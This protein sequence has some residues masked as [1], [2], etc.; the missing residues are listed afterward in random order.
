MAVKKKITGFDTETTGMNF[1]AGGIND[2]DRVCEIG[3]LVHQDGQEIDRYHTYVNPER[4]MPQDAYQIH[5]LSDSFLAD[6]PKFAEIYTDLLDFLI[7]H[8]AWENCAYNVD[9]DAI[10]L[11]LELEK[12]RRETEHLP[13]DK[14]QSMHLHILRNYPDFI[15]SRERVYTYNHDTGEYT[16]TGRTIK[17]LGKDEEIRALKDMFPLVDLL[18]VLVQASLSAINQKSG[19]ESL[20]TIAERFQIPNERKETHNA[21][22]DTILMLACYHKAVDENLLDVDA[23]TMR[24]NFEGKHI[25]KH[26]IQ[27][28][29]APEIAQQCISFE[30]RQ[31]YQNDNHQVVRPDFRAIRA[32]KKAIPASP[33]SDD[34]IHHTQ[35]STL[36]MR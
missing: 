17:E 12:I 26:I 6:K 20:D 34:E 3:I 9:F 33:N 31:N 7:K 2:H 23:T 29:V 4:N 11:S 14:K 22:D 28:R 8:D 30:N 5:K 24:L 19:R 13:D 36:R 35:S 27:Q 32:A 10:I 16:Y 15:P 1:G 25:P 21:V 18:P